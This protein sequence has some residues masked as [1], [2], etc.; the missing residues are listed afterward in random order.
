MISLNT[1][2]KLTRLGLPLEAS[3]K[4]SFKKLVE[5]FSSYQDL[6]EEVGVVELKKL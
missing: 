5:V 3:S 1:P 4:F 2:P 6:R